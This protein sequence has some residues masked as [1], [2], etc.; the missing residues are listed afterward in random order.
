VTRSG[1]I[2]LPLLVGKEPAFHTSLLIIYTF[3]KFLQLEIRK[4]SWV[5]FIFCGSL[6]IEKIFRLFCSPRYQLRDLDFPEC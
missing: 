5:G 6:L 3:K 2:V 1:F 4:I